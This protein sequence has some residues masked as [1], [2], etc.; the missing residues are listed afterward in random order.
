MHKSTAVLLCVATFTFVAGPTYAQPMKYRCTADKNTVSH[1]LR[2][3]VDDAKVTKFDYDA[4]TPVDG[5]TNSCSVDS[6]GARLA[7]VAPGIQ[8]FSTTAGDI[9]VTRK[10]KRFV[11]DFSKLNMGDLCGQSSVI[12]ARIA[13][14]PSSKRCTDVVNF[15]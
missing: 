9:L 15:N 2:V 12:A 3:T 4:S 6:A 10:G 11:F 7:D 14:T 13:L 5:S 8:S 1:Y